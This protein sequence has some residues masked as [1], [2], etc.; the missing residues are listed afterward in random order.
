MKTMIKAAFAATAL[1]TVLALAAI[2]C[3]PDAE[4]TA[5]DWSE[6]NSQ[7]NAKLTDNLND[8][9]VV[10]EVTGYGY[11]TDRDKASPNDEDQLPLSNTQDLVPE[12]SELVITFPAEADVLKVSN[13]KLLGELKKFMSFYTYITPTPATNEEQYVV[14]A[15][16]TELAYEFVKRVNRAATGNTSDP[17]KG[18]AGA[19]ITIRLTSLP[20]G[21][22]P[23]TGPTTG[24][25]MKINGKYKVNGNGLDLDDDGK[26]GETVYDDYYEDLT[27]LSHSDTFI[28]PTDSGPLVLSIGAVGTSGANSFTGA[29]TVSKTFTI[30]TLDGDGIADSGTDTNYTGRHKTIL[31]AL[32]PQFKVQKFNDATGK[33]VDVPEATAAIKYANAQL[34]TTFSVEHLSIYRLYASGL[35]G[36]KTSGL[37]DL[38]GG[39]EKKIAISGSFP[40]TTESLRI[41]TYISDNAGYYNNDTLLSVDA[42]SIYDVTVSPPLKSVELYTYDNAGKK[43]TVK[44]LLSPITVGSSKYFVKE[45]ADLFKKYLRLAYVISGGKATSLSSIDDDNIA[46]LK[47]T[48]VQF[49]RVNDPGTTDHAYTRVILT[50]DSNLKVTDSPSFT[51]LLA[52][53]F[54]YGSTAIR[55]GDFTAIDTV[56]DGIRGWAKYDDIIFN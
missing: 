24:V 17:L 9:T 49:E 53:G 11:K 50:I 3:A 21:P 34:E 1:V 19:D 39:A 28:P 27:V 13:D 6:Y 22:Q 32:I 16:G 30:A 36:L 20:P 35:K 26:A 33:W 25:V 46:F 40:N 29:N 42:S 38:Y 31:E 48:D 44:I 52:P 2:S 23:G 10:P 5:R 55:F 43:A 12:D 15:I 41:D 7:H 45:E 54:E 56:I 4:L 14:S 51:F 47:I 8:D 18:E 37:A